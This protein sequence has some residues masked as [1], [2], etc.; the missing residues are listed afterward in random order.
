M[1]FIKMTTN[2][3][4]T[5]PKAFRDKFATDYYICELKGG[6]VLFRPVEMKVYPKKKVK[7][8]MEDLKA[9]TFEDDNP[10][11]LSSEIDSVV[12]GI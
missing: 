12:Y 10:G 8:T 11:D 5:I 2:G 9:F 4:V 1:N 7:Y 3:Q 6:V